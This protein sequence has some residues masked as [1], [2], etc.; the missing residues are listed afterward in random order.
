MCLYG[1]SLVC[2]ITGATCIIGQNISQDDLNVENLVSVHY[3]MFSETAV[4]NSTEFL[5]YYIQIV[6]VLVL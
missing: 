4:Q 1:C 6:F 5:T 2:S 3:K